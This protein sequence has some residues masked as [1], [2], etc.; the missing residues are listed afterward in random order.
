MYLFE[1]Y[2]DKEA[3]LISDEAV[4]RDELEQA[5]FSKGQVKQAFTWLDGFH[6]F[7]NVT[8]D[9]QSMRIFSEEEMARLTAESRGFVLFLEQIGILSPVAREVVIDRAMQLDTHLVALSDVK[10]VA[11]M[12][13][14]HD[15]KF[16]KALSWMQEL[17][18][19]AE[20][21]H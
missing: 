17:V 8:L 7:D 19:H 12:V 21:L 6:L 15:P 3:E 13:L 4:L 11:L 9:D 20:Q 16:K 5:G 10:W 18:L 14:F 1:N 2:M